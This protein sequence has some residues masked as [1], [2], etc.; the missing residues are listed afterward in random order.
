MRKKL[1]LVI[2]PDEK[3]NKASMIY[4]FVMMF[5][6]VISM[7]PLAFKETYAIFLWFDYVTVAIFILDYFLRLITA[8][9][10]MGKSVFSRKY[11]INSR[12][13]TV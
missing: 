12:V 9:Y 3:G 13:F 7:I 8:D 1:F 11:S 5:T 4:D 6:I 10:K 2:E